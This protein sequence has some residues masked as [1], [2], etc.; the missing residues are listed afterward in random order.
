MTGTTITGTAAATRTGVRPSVVS[1]CGSDKAFDRIDLHYSAMFPDMS[2][3]AHFKSEE[4]YQ[5]YVSWY[6]SNSY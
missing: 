5:L 2:I 3:P 1:N 6:R 4:T